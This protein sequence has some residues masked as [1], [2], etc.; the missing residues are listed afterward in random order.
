MRVEIADIRPGDTIVLTV[1]HEITMAQ[2]DRI[3]ANAEAQFPG[4]R[5]VVLT[6]G[7]TLGLMRSAA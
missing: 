4:H 6:S 5:V 1:P 2:V 3:K 7:I